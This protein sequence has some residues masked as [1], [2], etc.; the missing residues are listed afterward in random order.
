VFAAPRSHSELLDLLDL[1]VT[2]IAA[3]SS[4]GFVKRMIPIAPDHHV[5]LR[6]I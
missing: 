2:A 6:V 5:N 4:S 1:T 3:A